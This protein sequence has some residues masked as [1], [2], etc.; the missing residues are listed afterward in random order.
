M[1]PVA[2]ALGV[3]VRHHGVGI[4][5]AEEVAVPK[6]DDLLEHLLEKSKPQRHVGPDRQLLRLAHLRGHR[7]VREDVREA[8][9]LRLHAGQPAEHLDIGDQLVAEQ[10]AGRGVG[11]DQAHFGVGGHRQA[12][13]PA[14]G[15][16]VF[17]ELRRHLRV[18]GLEKW[19]EMGEEVV[20]FPPGVEGLVDVL[21]V[22]E[23]I[24]QVGVPDLR[25]AVAVER[26]VNEFLVLQRLHH[27][28]GLHELRPTRPVGVGCIGQDDVVVHH[29]VG[30]Q[31]QH[32]SA[33]R[34]PANLHQELALELPFFDQHRRVPLVEVVFVEHLGQ[35]E[36][37]VGDRLGIEALARGQAESVGHLP[38]PPDV[39]QAAD[40]PAT[41]LRLAAIALED[42]LDPALPGGIGVGGL[43]T[44]G[45]LGRGQQVDR[46]GQLAGGRHQSGG[47]LSAA[48][49][50]QL[51]DA[52]VDGVAG[53]LPGPFHGI[54]SPKS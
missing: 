10:I 8:D 6:P 46:V 49:F 48:A 30:P 19:R 5:L 34:H 31:P 27:A 16:D 28:A 3:Q 50:G 22:V 45:R 54:K 1:Q 47:Q 52:G 15:L 44:A 21:G 14:D 4:E 26:H 23:S 32:R 51:A 25:F 12:E 29:P 20:E 36:Q 9:V 39:E 35:V 7:T 2:T 42:G 18:F 24:A 11:A 40:D 37:L 33:L 13:L 53:A 38:G 17:L 41:P 43:R